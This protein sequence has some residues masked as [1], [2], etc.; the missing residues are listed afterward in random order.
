MS[1]VLSGGVGGL[2]PREVDRGEQAHCASGDQ[3][4]TQAGTREGLPCAF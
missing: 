1:L 3:V 4:E 2:F